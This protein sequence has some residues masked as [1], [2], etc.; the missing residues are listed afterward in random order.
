M[1][2]HPDEWLGAGEYAIHKTVGYIPVVRA[3]LDAVVP[4]VRQDE[5]D[6][7][8]AW[9]RAEDDKHEEAARFIA[10]GYHREGDGR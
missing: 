4:L 9:L 3:V 2:D 1:T 8:V 10:N 6:R 5:R 7:I